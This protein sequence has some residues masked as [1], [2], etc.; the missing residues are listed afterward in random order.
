MGIPI[1][2]IEDMYAGTNIFQTGMAQMGVIPTV[3]YDGNTYISTGLGT[4]D[5]K[6]NLIEE[7]IDEIA[8]VMT[9]EQGKPLTEAKGEVAYANGFISW[10]AEEAKRVYGETIPASASN[11]RILVRKEPVGVIAAIPPW[12]FPAAMVKRKFAPPLAPCPTERHRLG[13]GDAGSR[14]QVVRWVRTFPMAII[15]Q[16]EYVIARRMFREQV[17]LGCCAALLG[18]CA[19]TAFGFMRRSTASPAPSLQ[20]SLT[21]PAPLPLHSNAVLHIA[22]PQNPCR[23]ARCTPSARAWSTAL[24]RTAPAWCAWRTATGEGGAPP[25]L[26]VSGRN[27]CFHTASPSAQT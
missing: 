20:W 13:G 24:R 25:L 19:C 5:S 21:L 23:T 4:C 16:R 1:F 7:N 15:A 8:K 18:C 2:S 22:L 17:R 9:I 10:F 6:G 12:N 11:K 27:Q 26:L 14:C 3:A